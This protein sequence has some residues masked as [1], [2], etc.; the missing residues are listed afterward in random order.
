MGK[1]TLDG[2]VGVQTALSTVSVTNADDNSANDENSGVQAEELESLSNTNSTMMYVI[3]GM[4][5]CL[6]LCGMVLCC[7]LF[8]RKQKKQRH[9][10][11]I[12]VMEMSPVSAVS[13][14]SPSNENTFKFVVPGSEGDNVTTSPNQDLELP[15]LPQHE[16]ENE[17]NKHLNMNFG[18]YDQAILP[19]KVTTTKGD[20]EMDDA[21]SSSDGDSDDEIEQNMYATA[22]KRVSRQ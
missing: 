10:K 16:Q 9:E 22:G 4:G 20:D 8:A 3:I 7:V 17:I 12:R 19:C 15:A 11:R 21:S 1:P 2:I 13:P 5:V 14:V 18:A 6:M